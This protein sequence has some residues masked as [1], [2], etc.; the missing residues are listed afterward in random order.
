MDMTIRLG[1]LLVVQGALTGAQRNE[2]LEIQSKSQRPFGVI[3]EERFGVSPGI[4]EMAWATQYASIA[5]RINPTAIEIDTPLLELVS[6]RQA[7]QFGLIPV[8]QLEGEIEFVTS[9]ECLIR[10]LRFVGW[11]IQ[12]MCT[13]GICDLPTLKRGLEMHYPFESA[14]SSM[15]DQM[16]KQHP[17]A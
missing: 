4:I 1:E 3:A 2:I 6:K 13:F 17:A 12:S 11:R 9:M 10:A 8:R 5:K 16:V 7:W 15:V 14:S